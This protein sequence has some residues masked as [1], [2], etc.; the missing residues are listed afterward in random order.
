MRREEWV[1]N[2]FGE[3]RATKRKGSKHGG[4][5]KS[6]GKKRKTLLYFCVK[7]ALSLTLERERWREEGR[8]RERE[9]KTERERE[10]EREG[11][12]DRERQR[13]RDRERGIE[14]ERGRERARERGGKR[15]GKLFH[16]GGQHS[17]RLC[18]KLCV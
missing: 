8:K 7:E 4:K 18:V 11:E 17:S 16:L 6:K 14:R 15:E 12:K 5:R 2:K 1:A 13:E 3:T 9:R 10:G